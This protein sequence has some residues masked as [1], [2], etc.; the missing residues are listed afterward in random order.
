MPTMSIQTMN[1]KKTASES[2][3]VDAYCPAHWIA[4]LQDHRSISGAIVDRSISV[5]ETGEHYVD[6]RKN[7]FDEVLSAIQHF[8]WQG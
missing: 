3:E 4:G 2:A 5:L 1:E 8:P 6:F 7:T